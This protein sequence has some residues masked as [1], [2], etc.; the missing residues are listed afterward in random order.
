ML[1]IKGIEIPGGK[2]LRETSI[3]VHCSLSLRNTFPGALNGFPF[4][5]GAD[6]PTFLLEQH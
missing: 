4:Y 5:I 2:T 6:P 3:P 1:M